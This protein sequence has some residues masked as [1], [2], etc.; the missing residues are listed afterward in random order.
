MQAEEV[1]IES[2]SELQAVDKQR[3]GRPRKVC[4]YTVGSSGSLQ[5]Y[6]AERKLFGENAY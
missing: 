2:E 6:A 1:S 3:S 4:R 5:R